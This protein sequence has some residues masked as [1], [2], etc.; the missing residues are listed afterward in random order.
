VR[1]KPRS[2][3]YRP[4]QRRIFY[5]SLRLGQ[6]R[7]ATVP[8]YFFD[9]VEER[10]NKRVRDLEGVSLGDIGDARREAISLAQDIRAH[11]LH[12]PTWQVAV[13]DENGHA[14]LTVP[15][16][17]VRLPR[18]RAWF[19]MV[20]RFAAYEPR[21]PPHLFTWLLAVAVTAMVL[22][23]TVLSQRVPEPNEGYA[24]AS[25]T[26]EAAVVHVRFVPQASVTDISKFLG[27]YDAA[28][29]GGP[30]PGG[31][32]RVRVSP[33][34]LPRDELIKIVRRMAGEKIVAFAAIGQ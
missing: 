20:F 18:M 19:D 30:H 16:G 24:L 27:A 10:T 29:I 14:V 22:Q 3:R 34:T 15:I 23:V 31:L 12:G 4:N 9:M 8:R 17:E 13:I 6:G 11:G 5:F 7:E 1:R 26:A 32:Y 33:A 21:L 25:A 28:L 2:F